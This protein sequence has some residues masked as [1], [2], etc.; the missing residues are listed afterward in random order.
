MQQEAQDI[1]VSSNSN[2]LLIA[3]GDFVVLPSD[4]QHAEHIMVSSKGNWINAPLVGVGLWNYLDA[5]MNS[6]V[7]RNLR[8]KI[9]LQLDYDGLKIMRLDIASLDNIRIT[10]TRRPF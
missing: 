5:P 10:A 9:T 4:T 6:L 1:A 2:E 7:L 8:H 3:N